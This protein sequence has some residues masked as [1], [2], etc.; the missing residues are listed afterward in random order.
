MIRFVTKNII[1]YKIRASGARK[2]ELH[3][4]LAEV[5]QRR[6][7]DEKKLRLKQRK[8]Q[9][10]LEIA[11]VEAEKKVY[12]MVVTLENYYKLPPHLHHPVLRH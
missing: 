9:L 6:L 2:Q 3:L 10:Q 12:A 11:K 4:K 5:A 1:V 7:Q 8:H